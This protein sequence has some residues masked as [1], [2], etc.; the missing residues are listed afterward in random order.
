M[1]HVTVSIMD[2]AKALGVSRSTIYEWC[3]LNKLRAI[4][5]GRRTLITVESIHALVAAANDAFDAAAA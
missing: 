5:L 4:K 2:A 3:Y 1:E